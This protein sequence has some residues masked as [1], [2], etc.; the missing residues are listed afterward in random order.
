MST[1]PFQPPTKTPSSGTGHTTEGGLAEAHLHQ[2][3][4]QSITRFISPEHQ[5]ITTP[6]DTT[7]EHQRDD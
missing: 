3:P 2:T 4:P 6:S 7:T 1:S 5:S